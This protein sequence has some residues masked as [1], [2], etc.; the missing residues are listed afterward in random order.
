MFLEKDK[1]KDLL[2]LVENEKF[3]V[4]LEILNKIKEEAHTI[5]C[6]E[7]DEVVVRW[8]Q[9]KLQLVNLLLDYLSE[10]R[11]RKVLEKIDKSTGN[12]AF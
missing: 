2:K 6:N 10:D 11:I 3:V 8:Q 7:K 1:L 4:I 9:G 12:T 5:M